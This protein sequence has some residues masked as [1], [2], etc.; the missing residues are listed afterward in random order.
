MQNGILDWRFSLKFWAI[1]APRK[2]IHFVLPEL[3]IPKVI[4][5][6]STSPPPYIPETSFS[7]TCMR[8]PLLL[9]SGNLL[10][11]YTALPFMQLS[12]Q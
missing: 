1:L 9:L 12:R 8:P 5:T 7:A 3:D 2:S 4:Q 11:I 10:D 6:T